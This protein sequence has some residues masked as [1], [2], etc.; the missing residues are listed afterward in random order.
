MKILRSWKIYLEGIPNVHIIREGSITAWV[1]N[2]FAVMHNS[3]TT[4]LE[5]TV[6]EKPLV[7]YIPFNQKHGYQLPNELGYCAKSKEELLGKINNLF[8]DMKSESKKRFEKP[9]PEQVLKKYI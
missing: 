8:N 4:A 1:N 6:S 2:A 3:C 5:A 7:T 9:L